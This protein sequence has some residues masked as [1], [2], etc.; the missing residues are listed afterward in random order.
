MNLAYISVICRLGLGQASQR[1][2][3][4]G[5]SMGTPGGV[6]DDTQEV[7]QEYPQIHE[8]GAFPIGKIPYFLG[9]SLI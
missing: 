7:S 1:V 6:P 8:S 3:H 9:T 4:G 2:H 5:G